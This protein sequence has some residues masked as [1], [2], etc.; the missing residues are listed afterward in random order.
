[1]RPGLQYR[2]DQHFPKT[3]R[4]QRTCVDQQ[5]EL[6]SCRQID[7]GLDALEGRDGQIN[8]RLEVQLFQ[9]GLVQQRRQPL[10]E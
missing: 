6:G 7:Q 8:Q 1:M 9:D 4:H 2:V 3:R 5:V 10:G